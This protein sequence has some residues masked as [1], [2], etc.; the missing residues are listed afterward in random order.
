MYSG[1]V[2]RAFISTTIA[3]SCSQRLTMVFRSVEMVL[4]ARIGPAGATFHYTTYQAAVEGF[5]SVKDLVKL[6]AQ[7]RKTRPQIPQIGQRPK[8]KKGPFGLPAWDPRVHGYLGALSTR[9]L[10]RLRALSDFSRPFK[11]P[12]RR[13]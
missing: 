1:Q 10:S 7:L 2:R 9:A 13:F 4:R 11:S 3:S 12:I 5:G 6:R 8:M